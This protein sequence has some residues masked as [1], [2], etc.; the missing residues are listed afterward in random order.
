[1]RKVSARASSTAW[2][3]RL[4]RGRPS[5]PGWV[6]SQIGRR[7]RLSASARATIGGPEHAGR[8][9]PTALGAAGEPGRQR[10]AW[11]VSQ[12]SSAPGVFA[13][14]ISGLAMTAPRSAAL[15]GGIQLNGP[16]EGGLKAAPRGRVHTAPVGPPRGIDLKNEPTLKLEAP[17]VT[18]APVGVDGERDPEPFD[19]G[20]ESDRHQSKLGSELTEIQ[21]VEVV[22]RRRRRSFSQGRGFPREPGEL[23]LSPTRLHAEQ[24]M[25]TTDASSGQQ[26]RRTTAFTPH[27][28]PRDPDRRRLYQTSTAFRSSPVRM[29]ASG[30]I[31][32]APPPM[33]KYNGPT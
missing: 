18:L 4:G 10:R 21:P 13:A 30:E 20:D 28:A 14:R 17:A 29:R 8:A 9:Y 7:P 1:M 6:C 16:F 19:Q 26:P 5:S 24:S 32:G 31:S 22:R 33:S 11:T 15:T 2:S 3:D 12:T 27:H 23:D 25:L